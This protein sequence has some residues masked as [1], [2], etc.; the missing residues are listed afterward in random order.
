MH[1][2]QVA[3]VVYDVASGN[4]AVVLRNPSLATMKIG[5]V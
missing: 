1:S 3:A 4:L 5:L 2:P